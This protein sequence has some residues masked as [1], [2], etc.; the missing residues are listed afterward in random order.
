MVTGN[1][2][3]ND[4]W[5]VKLSSTGAVVWKKIFGG[6]LDDRFYSVSINPANGN[7]FLTGY[8]SSI[9]GDVIGNHGSND[10]WVVKLNSSGTL[11]QQKCFGGTL[12][13]RGNSIDFE[14]TSTIMLAGY[15]ASS[16]GD[17]TVKIADITGRTVINKVFTAANDNIK[18][19][20]KNV[21]S[22]TYVVKVTALE[23]EMVQ[24]LVIN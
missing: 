3:G 20:V 23:R 11:L 1:H 22:G 24:R 18:V 19:D 17:V 2:G 21:A 5:I 13:D 16:N 15:C 14:N 6:T 9:D 4:A 12:S 7:I 8:T 10:L